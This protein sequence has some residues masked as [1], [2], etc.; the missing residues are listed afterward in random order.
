MYVLAEGFTGVSLQTIQ[1][2]TVSCTCLN[3]RS[4]VSRG[5]QEEIHR[6]HF[7]LSDAR[8]SS[9]E[10][11]KMRNMDTWMLFGKYFTV[12]KGKHEYQ[13]G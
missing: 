7:N 10:L 6:K 13:L 5:K 4:N 12:R 3:Q 2:L 8:C 9:A 11:K 1:I